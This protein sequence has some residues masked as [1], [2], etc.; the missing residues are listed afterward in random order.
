M[1]RA[2]YNTWIIEMLCYSMQSS[3]GVLGTAVKSQCACVS[4]S[5]LSVHCRFV[6]WYEGVAEDNSRS[7]GMA[8]SNDGISG[9]KR[10]DRSADLPLTNQP[11]CQSTLQ[12]SNRYISRSLL[13]SPTNPTMQPTG[14]VCRHRQHLLTFKGSA[15]RPSAIV[16]AQAADYKRIAW[17]EF[18]AGYTLPQCICRMH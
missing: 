15:R 16:D 17:C 3:K 11:F 1:C 14:L 5:L 6:M 12:N 4:P 10:W 7:I 8:V 13:S 2:W 9:W 18:C